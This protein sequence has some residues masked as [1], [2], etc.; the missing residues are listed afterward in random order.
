M[1]GNRLFPSAKSSHVQNET[2][3]ETFLPFLKMSF[4]SL[5]T[6]SHFRINGFSLSLTLKWRLGETWNRAVG[7][8]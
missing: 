6:E 2:K 5:R 1:L 7:N 3:C 4:I 8:K